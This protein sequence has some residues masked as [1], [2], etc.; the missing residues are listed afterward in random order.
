MPVPAVV[1]DALRSGGAFPA[2][3]RFPNPASAASSTFSWPGLNFKN[4]ADRLLDAKELDPKSKG[5]STTDDA[6]IAFKSLRLP[7]FLVW[8]TDIATDTATG[9]NLEEMPKG[10]AEALI[11]KVK[12]GEKDIIHVD[13]LNKDISHIELDESII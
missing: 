10:Q 6:R 8:N 11:N 13:D 12:V 7:V 4:D 9:E 3:S 5:E 2:V 1:A